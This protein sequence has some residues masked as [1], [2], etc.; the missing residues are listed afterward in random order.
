MNPPIIGLYSPTP[1][2]GKTTLARYLATFNY[3]IVSFATPLKEMVTAMLTN[4][5]YPH[6]EARE[7]VTNRK[8][9]LIPE[10]GVTSRHLLRTLG[11]EWGRDC[12]HPEVWLLSWEHRARRAMQ[13]GYR[14]VCDDCRFPDEADLIRSM[15]GELWWVHRTVFNTPPSGHRSDGGLDNYTPFDVRIDNN[16]SLIQLYDQISSR[17]S[18]KE[19]VTHAS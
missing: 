10:I 2:C 18:L 19:E 1:Q 16:G 15:D 4:L 7:L 17:L 8:E 12:V 9:V 13:E 3:R 14:V 6:V 11:T 5:G